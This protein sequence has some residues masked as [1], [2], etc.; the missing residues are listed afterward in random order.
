MVRCGILQNALKGGVMTK[1]LHIFVILI[2]AVFLPN[3]AMA[4]ANKI[5]DDYE[6]YKRT[7]ALAT[8][9][10]AAFLKMNIAAI[11]TS[12]ILTY[13]SKDGLAKA[14]EATEVDRQLGGQLNQLISEGKFSGLPS[15]SLFWK[16]NQPQIV[17]SLA[18][19]SVFS[20]L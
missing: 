13:C 2:A 9:M 15:Y 16:L 17:L 7:G 10:F 3:A 4:Q 1:R 5:A 20:K 6:T 14:V 11:R 19:I 12:A 18:I 8:E